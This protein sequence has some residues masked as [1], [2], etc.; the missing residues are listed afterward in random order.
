M[1]NRPSQALKISHQLDDR[2]YRL[3]GALEDLRSRT[4]ENERLEAQA[5]L[6]RGE[7]EALRELA[8]ARGLETKEL[9]EKMARCFKRWCCWQSLLLLAANVETQRKLEI[10]VLLFVCDMYRKALS[11]L[12]RICSRP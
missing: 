6:M 5:K 1:W 8:D 3:E 12:G 7:V 4:A 9:R 11:L 10:Y 2:R